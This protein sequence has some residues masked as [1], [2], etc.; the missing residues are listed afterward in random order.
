[1]DRWRHRRRLVYFTIGFSAA[2]ILIGAF[3]WTDRQVSS[4]LVVG[5]VSLLT[6]ILSGYVFA[7]TFDDKWQRADREPSDLDSPDRGAY[8]D[9][10][11]C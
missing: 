11:A 10:M 1:M 3:D 2:M 9:G 7:A 4:Q 6:L 5:G 8:G